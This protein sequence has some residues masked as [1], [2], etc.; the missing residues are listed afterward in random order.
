MILKADNTV[1]Q[2]PTSQFLAPSDTGLVLPSAD[3]A[4]PSS[5][6]PSLHRSARHRGRPIVAK[7]SGKVLKGVRADRGAGVFRLA[8]HVTVIN[9]GNFEEVQ[10]PV[11]F[12]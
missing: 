5:A 9:K 3:S 12:I 2:P 8:F 4:P 10:I 7:P 1:A 11:D 6:C